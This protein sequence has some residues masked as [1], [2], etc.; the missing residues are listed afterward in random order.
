MIYIIEGT[1]EE[2]SKLFIVVKINGL[3]YQVFITNFLLEKVKQGQHIKLFTYLEM[4]EGAIELYGFENKKERHY[5]KLLRSISGIGPKSSMNVLSLIKLNEL[6]QAIINEDL[7][8][9]TRVS[10]IGKK[11]AE[12]VILELKGKIERTA[13]YTKGKN[14][15]LIIDA[16][17]S[18][19]Y[20]TAQARE[21]VKKIPDDI[22]KTE[23][24]IKYA[25]LILSGRQNKETR[26]PKS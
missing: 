7:F 5:F 15:T 17:T 12:R 16:L 13:P 19:G 1:I 8:A 11:T 10:G 2:K 25:L 14:N 23:E 18:M 6:E 26:N 20:S 9:L 24:R 3:S 21:A 22:E 4:R